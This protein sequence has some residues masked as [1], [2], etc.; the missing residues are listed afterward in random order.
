VAAAL[1][2]APRDG[3]AFI[4]TVPAGLTRQVWLTFHSTD[5]PPGTHRGEILLSSDAVKHSLPL[6]LTVYP[7][8]FPGQ[9]ALHVGGWDY[10]DAVGR[11][12]TPGNRDAVI[13]HLREHCVDSP[14]ATAAVLPYNLDTARFDEWLQMWPQARQ[15]C[16]F[17][18]V[19]D[20]LNNAAM[21]TPEF[22]QQVRAFPEVLE[23]HMLMGEKDFLLKVVTRDVEA[24]EQFLRH[25][26]ST[27][28]SVQEVQSSM[29]LTTVK[30]TARLPLT[31]LAPGAET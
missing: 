14:W 29:A 28:P 16:V 15:Y 19:G 2:E 26:L 17:A 31:A 1:P 24:Y 21:G 8:R 12:I 5:L 23:C 30:Q 9:P 18:S 6:L 11:D 20:T 3:D 27:L 4:I 22:E 13:R 7:L 10:T 25:R